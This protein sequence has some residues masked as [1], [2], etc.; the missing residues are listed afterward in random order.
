MLRPALFIYNRE[1]LLSGGKD[2]SPSWSRF[3]LATKN[4]G[5]VEVLAFRY[6]VSWNA[7]PISDFEKRQNETRDR[8]RT[9]PNAF[10]PHETDQNFS[11]MPEWGGKWGN[12]SEKSFSTA[13]NGKKSPKNG[14]MRRE[15]DK[16]SRKTVLYGGRASK[17]SGDRFPAAGNGAFS[18]K[19]VF[20]RRITLWAFHKP[21][22]RDS[23]QSLIYSQTEKDCE[24]EPNRAFSGSSFERQ[25]S[26]R[27]SIGQN[28]NFETLCSNSLTTLLLIGRSWSHF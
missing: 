13:G 21:Y 28:M 9:F 27:S 22:P 14:F 5:R 3:R 11:E 20:R 4:E 18:P 15:T 23:L 19:N 24:R 26:T 2:R 16:I 1:H 8:S 12:F 7:R 25:S 6:S 17:N 10:P